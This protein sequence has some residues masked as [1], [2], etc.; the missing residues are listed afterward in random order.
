MVLSIYLY[1]H[2]EQALSFSPFQSLV[3]GGFL[4]DHRYKLW[5]NHP[6]DKN[7]RHGHLHY[8]LLLPSKSDWVWFKVFN[9]NR[10]MDY[11][12]SNHCCDFVGFVIISSCWAALLAQ[13][14]NRSASVVWHVLGLSSKSGT[15]FNMVT[16]SLLELACLCSKS[17]RV[18]AVTLL[19]GL[20]RDF[21]KAF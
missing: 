1:S 13:P 8:K 3:I 21:S 14:L 19:L 16:T 7:R 6:W 4:R 2:Y 9:F 15:I 5:E 11:S 10:V 18:C 20:V 12:A 17:P